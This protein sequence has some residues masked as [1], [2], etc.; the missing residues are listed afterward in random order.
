MNDKDKEAFEKS[1]DVVCNKENDYERFYAVWQAAC[2]YMRDE[3]KFQ[4]PPAV[5]AYVE[6]NDKLVEENK[7]LREAL[8]W[9]L[10][11]VGYA[12]PWWI[13]INEALKEVD[14]E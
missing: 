6:I 14:E 7:K 10:S 9:C 1:L 5:V 13:K 3:F 12:S 11:Q 8:N 4:T 2:E